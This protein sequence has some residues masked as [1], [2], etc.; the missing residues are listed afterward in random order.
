MRKRLVGGATGG[1][2]MQGFSDFMDGLLIA[3]FR[4]VIQQGTPGVRAGWQQCCLVAM[5]GYGRRELAPFSDIDVMVLTQ[6]NHEEMGQALSKGVFHR[7]VGFGVSSRAI[8][9]DPLRNV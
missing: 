9:F 2:I 6:G 7:P 5:G 1:E 4:E 8:V 3:R